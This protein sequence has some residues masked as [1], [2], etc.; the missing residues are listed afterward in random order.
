ML[1]SDWLVAHQQ[2]VLH[3]DDEKPARPHALMAEAR[4]EN[5]KLIYRG[6]RMF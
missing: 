6:D 2:E 1:V 4:I 3:I 5:G